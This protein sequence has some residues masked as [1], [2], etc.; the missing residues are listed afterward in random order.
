MLRDEACQLVYYSALLPWCWYNG[1]MTQQL[2][3][4]LFPDT[5]T[6]DSARY[7]VYCPI[8]RWIGELALAAGFVAYEVEKLHD[9]NTKGKN[10]K[11]RVPLKDGLLWIEG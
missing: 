10:R 4:S 5:T 8:D 1:H 9:R 2:Q 11:H 3:L 6:G 7:G